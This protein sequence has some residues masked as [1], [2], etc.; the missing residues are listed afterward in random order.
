M[1]NI[2][3]FSLLALLSAQSMAADKMLADRHVQRGL[4]CVSCHGKDMSKPIKYESCLQCHG[5]TYEDLAKKTDELDINPHATH[6]GEVSCMECHQGHQK[7]RL[8]CIQCHEFG[9]MF[10]VP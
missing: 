7:P 2:F 10:N 6:L 1:K 8:A 4:N 9:D 3:I 5:P